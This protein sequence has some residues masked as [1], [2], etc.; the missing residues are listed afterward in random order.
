[1]AIKKLKK[2]SFLFYIIAGGGLVF[3]WRGVWGLAD[4]YLL[5]H[6]PAASY[7]ASVVIG[8]VLLLIDDLKLEELDNNRKK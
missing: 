5:P 8:I 2:Q 3:F 4:L 7:I 6:I 1:M